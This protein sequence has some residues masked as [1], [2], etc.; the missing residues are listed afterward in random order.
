[1]RKAFVGLSLAVALAAGP[2]SSVL[3]AELPDYLKPISGT[4]QPP[5]AQ[6]IATRNVLQL[7][8]TMFTLYEA[9][10]RPQASAKV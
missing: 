1:M 5:S 8:T 7:N 9:A 10:A 2:V 6:D 3:A 4:P